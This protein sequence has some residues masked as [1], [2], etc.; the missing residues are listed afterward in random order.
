MNFGPGSFDTPIITNLLNTSLLNR[1]PPLS[2]LKMSITTH[3]MELDQFYGSIATFFF[4]KPDQHLRLVNNNEQFRTP[5]QEAL[6]N[7]D[8]KIET[9]RKTGLSTLRNLNNKLQTRKSKLIS[10]YPK[11]HTLQLLFYSIQNYIDASTTRHIESAL[12]LQNQYID[13]FITLLLDNNVDETKYYTLYQKFKKELDDRNIQIVNLTPPPSVPSVPSP[14]V[15]PPSVPPPSVPPPSVP[16]PSVPPPSVPPALPPSSVALPPSV[17]PAPPPSSLALL[18]PS[19]NLPPPVNLP[20]QPPQAGGVKRRRLKFP[21]YKYYM[22]A[23]K[24]YSKRKLKTFRKRRNYKKTK[25][26]KY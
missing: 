5:F 8:S 13:K 3:I 21:S 10:T 7:C 17:P 22:K 25:R 15:P 14:S 9:E 24:T 1:R 2:K 4:F 16:P 20:P 12:E 6:V 26:N 23:F 18:H 11:Y 19:V